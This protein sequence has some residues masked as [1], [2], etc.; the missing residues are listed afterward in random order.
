MIISLTYKG[1]IKN[2]K[3]K[4]RCRLGCL[5]GEQHPLVSQECMELLEKM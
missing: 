2:T 3:F 5:D 1:M 4:F